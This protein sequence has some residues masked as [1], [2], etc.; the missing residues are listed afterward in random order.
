M[1]IQA[2]VK[3]VGEVRTGTSKTTGKNWAI[4]DV[5][6]NWTDEAGESY[7]SASIDANLWAGQGI[8]VGDTIQVELHFYTKL[9]PSCKIA[10]EIRI[11]NIN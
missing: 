1:K 7:I 8:E 5:L 4:R 6:L 10:N 9:L 11:I 3:R 2:K